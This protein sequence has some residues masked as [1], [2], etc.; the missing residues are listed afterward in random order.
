[1]NGGELEEGSLAR[2]AA[3][4][5]DDVWPAPQSGDFGD[6]VAP[7]TRDRRGRRRMLAGIGVLAVVAAVGGG[8]FV[9]LH[10]EP[11][12]KWDAD[13]LPLARFV[14]NTRGGRYSKAV[15]IVFE[16]DKVYKKHFAADGEQP[17]KAALADMLG[18]LR[19]LGVV[20]GDLDLVKSGET[21]GAEGTA[22]FYS[23]EDHHIHVKGGRKALKTVAL[24]TTLVHELTHAYD[25]Q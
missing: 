13:V 23:P 12:P 9:V 5:P 20:A 3:A 25:D 17:D 7:V 19:A 14:E 6:I 21:L 16:S 8:L 11:P 22:G 4:P 15:P 1:M 2:E 24:R 18:E 10:R